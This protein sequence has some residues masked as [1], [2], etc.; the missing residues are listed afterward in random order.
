M[1]VLGYVTHL[2]PPTTTTTSSYTPSFTPIL[3]PPHPGGPCQNKPFL[4]AKHMSCI[5]SFRKCLR[6]AMS[7]CF[8]FFFLCYQGTGVTAVLINEWVWAGGGELGGVSLTDGSSLFI[9]GT[10][11]DSELRSESCSVE[12]APGDL[13]FC[14]KGFKVNPPPKVTFF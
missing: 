9:A 11:Y 10:E 13:I 2:P 6:R 1:L 7:C 3:P 8:F 4:Q 5:A 12:P 14:I